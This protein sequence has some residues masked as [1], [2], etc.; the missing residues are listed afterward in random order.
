MLEV[1]DAA[2]RTTDIDEFQC[3][4]CS[5]DWDDYA[6]HFMAGLQKYMMGSGEESRPTARKV[7]KM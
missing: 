2:Q 3:D 7:M 4:V 1:L 6:K 5:I